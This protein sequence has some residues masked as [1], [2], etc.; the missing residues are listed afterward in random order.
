MAGEYAFTIE[1]LVLVRPQIEAGTLRALAVTSAARA[2]LMPSVATMAE[3][4]FPGFTAGGWYGLLAPGGVGDDV[5]RVLHAAAVQALAEPE[6]N[7]RVAEMGSPAIGGTPEA[8]RAHIRAET[9]RWRSV[10]AAAR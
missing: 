10:M 4:G 6:V 1:N 7:R 3:Q 9:A 5:V 2:P 8:F